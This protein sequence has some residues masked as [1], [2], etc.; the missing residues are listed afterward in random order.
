MKLTTSACNTTEEVQTVR[1]QVGN[2]PIRHERPPVSRVSASSDALRTGIAISPLDS[3]FRKLPAR[4]LKLITNPASSP[5]GIGSRELP[6]DT[7][8]QVEF[9]AKLIRIERRQSKKKEPRTVPILR[10]H[11]ALTR[12]ADLLGA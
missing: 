10:R 2:S 6:K 4:S 1:G 7:I 9:D 12:R 3:G 11:G 5:N 8:D